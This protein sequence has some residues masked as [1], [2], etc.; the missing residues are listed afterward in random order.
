MDAGLC[1]GLREL[2]PY[3]FDEH[4][5]MGYHCRPIQGTCYAKGTTRQSFERAVA[6]QFA[7]SMGF[8]H[9]IAEV[10]DSTYTPYAMTPRG[11]RRRCLQDLYN[12]KHRRYALPN[13]IGVNAIGRITIAVCG[14]SGNVSDW[15][16]LKLTA[17]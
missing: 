4:R 5:G 9:P 13:L 8:F 11:L 3:R 1:N 15:E 16:I 17:L 14:G 12:W 10:F 2:Y 6:E 7:I